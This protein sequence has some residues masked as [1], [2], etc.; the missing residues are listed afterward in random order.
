MGVQVRRVYGASMSPDATALAHLIDDGGYPRAVQR[1][2]RGWRATSS[3]DVELPVDGPVLRVMHSADGHWLAC[4]VAPEGGTRSQIWV[5]TTDPDDRDARRIDHWPDGAPEGH[6]EL[7]AWDGAR[8]AAILTG[9]DGVGNSCLIDPAA[10]HTVVVDRRSGGRLVDAWAG[11]ALVRVGPRGYRDL[12]MLR[13]VTEIALLPYDPGSTTDDGI[14][15]DDH[16]PRRVRAGLEGH[17]ELYQPSGSYASSGTEGFVRALIRSENGAEHARL[18]EVIAIAE[19]VSYQIVAERAGYELDEF[20]VSDDLSTVAMLWNI[21]GASELQIL[22]LA[23]YTLHPP[24]PLPG[25]VASQLSISAG[26]TMLAMTVEGPSTPPTVELVNPRTR[27]W[28]PVDREPS[29]GPVAADPTLEVITARDGLEFTGWLFRPPDGVEPIGAMLFLHGGP[30]GQGRPGYNEFFPPLLEAGISVFLPNVRGSGGFGR[31]FMHADDRQ[32]RFAA[33]DDVADAVRF[34]TDEARAPADRIACCGW[35]Y[36]GYL[37]QAALAFH[38]E[39]FAAGI[40][41]CGMS[42]LNTWYRSTEPW[43]AAAAYPK[44]GHPVSDRDL[45]DEL[46]PLPRAAAVTAPMLLVHGLNDTNVPPE[47]SKQMYDALRSLGRTVELLT[48]EDDGHEIDKRENRAVLVKAMREWLIDAFNPPG[49][50]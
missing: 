9:D 19:G 29:L 24:I 49:R 12:I 36:G 8:V 32:R 21:Y 33:I 13:G 22:E 20:A 1:F 40:S 18:L 5:V 3:R 50:R 43:I 15:L 4:E 35:S 44:Y 47:E 26:G 10:G 38:P 28:E 6:A 37:T 30:E 42:D 34:L 25:L 2:L 31:S 7:I 16:S 23:D 48:F 41:I 17:N 46:S 14:I 39:L 11:S 27:E 45:L